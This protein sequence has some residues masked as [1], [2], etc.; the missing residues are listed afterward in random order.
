MQNWKAIC[1]LVL[2]VGI[3]FKNLAQAQDRVLIEEPIHKLFR[4]MQE[5]DSAIV[6]SAFAENITMATILK[7]KTGK[8]VLKR[9]SSIGDFLNAV[10]QPHPEIWYEEI[11]DLNIQQDGDF[12]QAWCHYAFY[13]GNKFS[14]CGVD[15]FHLYRQDGQW[16][17]FHLADTRRRSDCSVPESI[18]KKHQ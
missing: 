11:W 1:L 6:R 3:A 16:K 13:L 9:E 5:G 10:S 14:H 18:Q 12:A 7:D 17:I 15:A 8:V 4:G 2:F